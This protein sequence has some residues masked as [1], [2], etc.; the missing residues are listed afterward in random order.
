[1]GLPLYLCWYVKKKQSESARNV[2]FAVKYKEWF[3]KCVKRKILTFLRLEWIKCISGFPQLRSRVIWNPNFKVE[4]DIFV[5]SNLKSQPSFLSDAF[6]TFFGQISNWHFLRNK[7]ERKTNKKWM[8]VGKK[9]LT[10]WKGTL[11]QS[12]M[13]KLS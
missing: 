4:V 10:V 7:K 6:Y 12:T 3:Q 9:C 5:N 13:Q 11:C 8:K 2:K 1:M